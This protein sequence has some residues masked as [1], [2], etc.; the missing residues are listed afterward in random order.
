MAFEYP[1]GLSAAFPSV[2]VERCGSVR[3][4][5]CGMFRCVAVW[6]FIVDNPTSTAWCGAV[7]LAGMMRVEGLPLL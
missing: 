3:N 4:M 6:F 5:C 2:R 7:S 1:E